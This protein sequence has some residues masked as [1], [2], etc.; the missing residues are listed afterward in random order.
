M[1]SMKDNDNVSGSVPE[2]KEGM[3]RGD[4]A[5]MLHQYIK[6]DKGIRDIDDIS[7]AAVL[8]D[9]YDCRVC[10]DHIA[11]VYLRGLMDA[12]FIPGKPEGFYIFDRERKVMREEFDETICRIRELMRQK[13]TFKNR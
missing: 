7:G 3:T 9:L 13:L 2:Y 11:Q 6:N 12:F 8:K 10:V 1:I 5:K 4:L